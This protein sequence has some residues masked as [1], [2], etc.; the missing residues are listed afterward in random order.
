MKNLKYLLAMAFMGQASYGFA[1]YEV[2]ALR[3]S[4][5]QFGGTARSLGIGAPTWL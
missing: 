3:F 4:Q 2:D 1:Q 5:T